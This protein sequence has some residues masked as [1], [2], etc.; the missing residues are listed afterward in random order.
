MTDELE[1]RLASRGAALVAETYEGEEWIIWISTPTNVA[2]KAWPVRDAWDVQR[3]GSEIKV[4]HWGK[5]W[6][7][8]SEINESRLEFTLEDYRREVKKAHANFSKLYEG[9]IGEDED[10]PLLFADA[11]DEFFEEFITSRGAYDYPD[12]LTPLAFPIPGE[13]DAYTPG[14]RTDDAEDA[15]TPSAGPGE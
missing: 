14:A 3:D 2:F 13:G 15:G 11:N 9:R 10:L 6:F 5:S 7:K 8:P 12:V 1:E 4:V